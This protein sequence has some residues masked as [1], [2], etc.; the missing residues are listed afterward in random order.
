M[1]DTSA[2]STL[3][4][5]CM[6]SVDEWQLQSLP[7]ASLSARPWGVWDPETRQA[8]CMLLLWPASNPQAHDD[9]TA[10]G[11][12]GGWSPNSQMKPATLS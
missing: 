5:M 7:D 3:F 1:Y 11:T 4:V 8:S 2:S 10:T 9:F 6:S 12:G